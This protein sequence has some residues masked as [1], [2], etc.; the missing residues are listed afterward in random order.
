MNPVV[1]KVVKIV[2]K[3]A[4]VGVPLAVNYFAD[5][6]LNDTITKKATEAVAEALKNQVGES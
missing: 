6:D 2:L 5:K 4:S 3:V 1:T